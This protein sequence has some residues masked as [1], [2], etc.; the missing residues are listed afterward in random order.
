MTV[1]SDI[2]GAMDALACA[3]PDLSD[4]D[5]KVL[6]RRAL[7]EHIDLSSETEMQ[8]LAAAAMQEVRQYWAQDFDAVRTKR[9]I[10]REV[11]EA[12]PYMRWPDP[13]TQSDSEIFLPDVSVVA[14]AYWRLDQYQR[15]FMARLTK[16]SPG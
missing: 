3:L 10:S 4:A 8:A 11:W 14:G 6:A 9:G 15:A 7:K 2:A 1:K 13:L 12:R 16:Q 5:L